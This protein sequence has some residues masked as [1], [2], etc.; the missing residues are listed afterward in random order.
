M[1]EA[2]WIATAEVRVEPG[3]VPSGNTLGFMKITMWAASEQDFLE[4]VR[5]YFK[6]YQW[7]LLSIDHTFQIDPDADYGDEV[8]RMVDETSENES[9]VRL[10]TYYSYKPE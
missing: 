6:K 2:I 1:P 3:D 4:R 10:G 5:A 9:F 8:N 7:D